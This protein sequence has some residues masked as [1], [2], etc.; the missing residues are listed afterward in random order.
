MIQ[1]ALLF[2]IRGLEEFYHHLKEQK[3]WIQGLS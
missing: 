3:A 1:W 2:P